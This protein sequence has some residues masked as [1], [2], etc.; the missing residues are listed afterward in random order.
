MEQE[1]KTTQSI[2]SIDY[3]ILRKFTPDQ[4]KFFLSLQ[5]KVGS[6]YSIEFENG[7]LILVLHDVSHFKFPKYFLVNLE[8]D[9]LSSLNHLWVI[10]ENPDW[11]NDIIKYSDLREFTINSLHGSKKHKLWL[12]DECENFIKEK[13]KNK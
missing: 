11:E 1:S 9:L 2:E 7:N 4:I 13:I 10:F 6:K 12:I 8:I 5:Q 3:K